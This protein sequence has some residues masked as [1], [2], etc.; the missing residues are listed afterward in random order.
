LI[1]RL[2]GCWVMAGTQTFTVADWVRE[3]L[4]PFVILTQYWVVTAGEAA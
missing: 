3:T 4:P 1:I 2:A